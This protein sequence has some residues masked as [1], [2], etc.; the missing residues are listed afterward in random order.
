MLASAYA[1]LSFAVIDAHSYNNSKEKKR[2]KY[3]KKNYRHINKRT[4][5]DE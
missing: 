1:N 2:F 5:N 4:L 3:F